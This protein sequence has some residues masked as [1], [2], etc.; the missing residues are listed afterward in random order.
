MAMFYPANIDDADGVARAISHLPL[1]VIVMPD[2]ETGFALTG[3]G[4]D[5]TWEICEADIRAGLYPPYEL[6]DLPRYADRGTGERDVA[7]LAACIES[8]RAVM[9]RAESSLRRL[10]ERW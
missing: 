5:L 10:K 2:G 3:G 7:I 6:T 8:C 4:M 1:C 9:E